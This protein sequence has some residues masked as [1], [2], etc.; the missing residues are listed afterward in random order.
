MVVVLVP[1]QKLWLAVRQ[2]AGMFSL[3]KGRV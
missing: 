1:P 2:R 3:L